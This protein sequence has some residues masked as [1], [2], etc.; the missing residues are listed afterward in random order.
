MVDFT[1]CKKKAKLIKDNVGCPDSFKTRV[2]VDV[3]TVTNKNIVINDCAIVV[4]EKKKKILVDPNDENKGYVWEVVK[5]K[6]GE[7]IY[8][9]TIFIGF[10][11]KYIVSNYENL[12]DIVI[13]ASSLDISFDH[14]ETYTVSNLIGEKVKVGSEMV[15]YKDKSG[16]VTEYPKPILEN[17]D[18]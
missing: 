4:K 5:N 17:P 8:Q 14:P 11:D 9:P 10:D 16:K 12:I 2:K 6:K 3:S 15:E 1:E 7:I 18:E 13:V